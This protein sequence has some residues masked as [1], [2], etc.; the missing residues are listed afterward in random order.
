MLAYVLALAVAI[1]SIAIYMVAF[2]FPE[3]H[4]K[5]DFIWSGIGLFYALVIWI[6]ARRI[7]GGLLLGHVA[8]VS[9]LGWFGWQTFSLRRQLVPVTQQT[10]VPSAE[11]VKATVEQQVN[12]ISLPQRLGGLFSGV[13]NKAQQAINKKK[14]QDT[15]SA[16]ASPTQII[17]ALTAVEA[18]SPTSATPTETVA[19]ISDEVPAIEVQTTEP[20]TRVIEITPSEPVDST[21]AEAV[22]PNPP[23]LEL[24]EAAQPESEEKPHIPVEEVAPDAVLAPP[25]E[26]PTDTPPNTPA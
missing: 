4:R 19:A 23:S 26:T 6:F 2:F 13:K 7:S 16:T 17:E 5:N 11:E 3:I 12:K 9:L 1:G 18:E 24:V 20:D 8:S 22:P 10:A 25:A 15:T 14:P 21:K